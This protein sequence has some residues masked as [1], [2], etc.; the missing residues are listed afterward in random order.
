MVGVKNFVG[1]NAFQSQEASS[2]AKREWTSGRGRGEGVGKKA[3]EAF[4]EKI[5]CIFGHFVPLWRSH[6]AL[7][8]APYQKRQK[9]IS[10]SSFHYPKAQADT[11]PHTHFGVVL[12]PHGAV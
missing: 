2:T 4:E 10:Q 6:V 9:G 1:P 12:V 8:F 7:E 11:A 3:T 5:D